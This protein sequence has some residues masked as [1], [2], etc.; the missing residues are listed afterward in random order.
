M[1]L[2]T[3]LFSAGPASAA[4]GQRELLPSDPSMWLNSPPL[5]AEALKGKGVF[6]WFYEETC[7]RCRGKW[8][9]L[10]ELAKKYEGQPVVFIA[11]NSGNSPAEVQQYAKEVKLAWPTIVD[12]TRQF[13]K[14]WLDTVISLQNIHQCEL[15]LPSGKKGNGRWD[16][17]EGSVKTA[18]E[19]A[20][21]KIDPKTIPTALLPTWQLVELG[22]YAAAANMLKKGLVT[23]NA[24]VKEAVTRVNDFVQA[25]LKSAV[26]DAAKARQDGDPWQA[27]QRYGAISATFAGYDLPPDVAAAKKELASDP[28]V[29]QQLEAAKALDAIKKSFATARTDSARKRVIARLQQLANQ[30]ADTDAAGEVRQLLD[31]GKQEP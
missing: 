23:K 29:K 17:L 2:A 31:Q 5:T 18:L 7:P 22:N 16:D 14:Q 24:E 8:P 4:D 28:K 21:W 9:G 12:P 13:E 27:F 15:I 10:Y 26:A 30:Y 19:G 11:V 6:L 20:H 1:L 25:Q 3:L